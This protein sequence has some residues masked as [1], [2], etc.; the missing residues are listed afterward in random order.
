M[1]ARSEFS[2]PF[3]NR[4]KGIQKLSQEELCKAILAYQN[5]DII[6]ETRIL[7]VKIQETYQNETL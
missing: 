3:C 6:T 7:C 1:K 4:W 5:D 2:K